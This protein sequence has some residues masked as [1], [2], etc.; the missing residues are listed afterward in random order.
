MTHRSYK[1]LKVWQ[2]ADALFYEIC[3]EVARWPRN[4]ITGTLIGQVVR[5]AG[6]I[7]ANIVEGYGR[8]TKKEFQRYLRV[9]RGSAVETDNWLCKAKNLKYMPAERYN[10]YEEKIAEIVKMTNSFMHALNPS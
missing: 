3:Q 4:L 8:G 6:S 1:D 9:A 5:S 7:S 2:K 10:H